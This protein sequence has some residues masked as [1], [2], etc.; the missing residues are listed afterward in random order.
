[1]SKKNRSFIIVVQIVGKLYYY[2]RRRIMTAM[3]V[4]K[5]KYSLGMK[6]IYCKAMDEIAAAP[7]ATPPLSDSAGF[8]RTK[9]PS[10][11]FISSVS[12]SI[13]CR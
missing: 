1:M 10:F 12:L 7:T 3:D 6:I 2:G 13:S 8:V 4:L 11:E 9:C 5:D